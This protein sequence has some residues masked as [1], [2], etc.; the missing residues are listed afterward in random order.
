MSH[1]VRNSSAPGGS[2]AQRSA[3]PT[4]GAAEQRS[5][6]CLP[7]VEARQATLW[8]RARCR[9]LQR[10]RNSPPAH[11]C[12]CPACRRSLRPLQTVHQQVMAKTGGKHLTPQELAVQVDVAYAQQEKQRQVQLQQAQQAAQLQQ[13]QAA[14]PPPPGQ[15]PPAQTAQGMPAPGPNVAAGTPAGTPALGAAPGAPAGMQQPGMQPG[16]PAAGTPPLPA[17]TPP[18]QAMTVAPGQLAQP[19]QAGMPPV[20]QQQLMQPAQAQQGA[21]LP[22]PAGMAG[23]PPAPRPGQPQITLQQLNHILETGKLP[24]GQVRAMPNAQ[25]PAPLAERTQGV[26]GCSAENL[27]RPLLCCPPLLFCSSVRI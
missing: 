1:Q 6:A 15:Q 12:V 27:V 23:H 26:S 24:N 11:P 25:L 22:S 4:S 21:A 14:A 18:L 7:A 19:Q 13:Q 5:A 10:A 17:G 3:V 16:L 8:A 9:M 2:V 20:Q